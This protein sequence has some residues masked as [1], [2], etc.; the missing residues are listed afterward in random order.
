M[1]IKIQKIL[2][3]TDLYSLPLSGPDEV[4]GVQ[5]LEKL[6]PVI[7]AYARGT[8]QFN[9]EGGTATLTSGVKDTIQEVSFKSIEKSW[10]RGLVAM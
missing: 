2:I 8:M 1:P 6:G 3:T 5:W 7:S 4:L 9:C 10:K